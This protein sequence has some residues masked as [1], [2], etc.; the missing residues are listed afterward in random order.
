MRGA[1]ACHLSYLVP[2]HGKL[3]VAREGGMVQVRAEHG[4]CEDSILAGE[5]WTCSGYRPR[6]VCVSGEGPGLDA[7]FVVIVAGNIAWNTV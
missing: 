5:S 6:L 2:R 7:G 3:A 4:L 1:P